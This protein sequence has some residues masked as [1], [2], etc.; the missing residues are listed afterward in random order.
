MDPELKKGFSEK[1]DVEVNEVNFDNLEAM[2]VKLRSGAQYDIIWPSTEYVSR[3]AREGLLARFDRDSLRN[4]KN[5]SSFYDSPWWDPQNEYSIP[6]TYY[7]TGIAWRDDE[8]SGLTGS[9]NDLTLPDGEGR[10]FILDDFQEAIGEANLIDGL[11]PQHHLGRRA[12]GGQGDADRPEGQRPRVLDQLR[13]EPRLG[14]RR[15]APGLERRHRQ[16]PQ[17]GRRARA[18]QVRDLR[19]RASR[20]APT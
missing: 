3:L 6:Y 13:A 20:S 9:W 1:Y 4:S 11:R 16:R 10:M 2:V 19:R 8:V 12:R 14:H 5:I 15:P 7:T 17:P 18:L